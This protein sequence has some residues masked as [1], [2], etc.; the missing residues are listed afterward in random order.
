MIYDEPNIFHNI[1]LSSNTRH[2]L[3][4]LIE[5]MQ[6]FI[7]STD[8]MR[9]LDFGAGDC[10]LEYSF[11]SNSKN[12]PNV[13][14]DIID[15]SKVTKNVVTDLSNRYSQHA[16]NYKR[17]LALKSLDKPFS[18]DIALFIH[19]LYHVHN[20]RAIITHL[21]LNNSKPCRMLIF[22]RSRNSDS[23]K[24]KRH[25]LKSAMHTVLVS[26][27]VSSFLHKLSINHEAEMVYSQLKFSWKSVCKM[28][29][30]SKPQLYESVAAQI[31]YFYLYRDI[32]CFKDADIDLL[33]EYYSQRKQ[34]NFV[35]MNLIDVA[36][37]CTI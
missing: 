31:G 34:G 26:E 15:P 9:I 27:D 8:D 29:N 25:V 35:I 32:P 19:S 16:F 28:L 30:S 17:Y 11:C 36:F 5:K 13:V 2:I 10:W 22:I 20:W 23:L 33:H 4:K 12:I 7:P 6:Y 14:F 3:L 1:I 21:C 24:L 18:Y 37:W